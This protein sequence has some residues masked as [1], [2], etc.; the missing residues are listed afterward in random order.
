MVWYWSSRAKTHQHFSVRCPHQIFVCSSWLCNACVCV[1]VCHFVYF[2][3]FLT[4]DCTAHQVYYSFRSWKTLITD[5]TDILLF[6]AI[7]TWNY[8]RFFCCCCCCFCCCWYCCCIQCNFLCEM[9]MIANVDGCPAF[10]SLALSGSSFWICAILSPFRFGSVQF[11]V[12]VC[13][14][15]YVLGI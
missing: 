8:W 3:K 6:I 12:F 2:S 4:L 9:M 7:I 10:F 14:A 1:C 5:S 11:T 13:T 15:V